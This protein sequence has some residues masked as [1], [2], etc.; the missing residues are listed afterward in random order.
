MEIAPSLKKLE[1]QLS[2][3]KVSPFYFVEGPETFLFRESLR[4]LQAKLLSP[5]TLD[6]NYDVFTIGEVA[7]ARVCEVA[8]TLPVFSSKRMI[9]CK[10]AHRMRE[11]DSKQLEAMIENPIDTCVLVFASTNPDKRKKMI[12]YLTSH[13]ELI[14]AQTPKESEWPL[15]IAWMGRKMKLK[16]SHSG[17]SL[18]RQ[19]A[20]Y[21]LIGLENEMKKLK[22]FLGNRNVV[23]EE[24]ILKIVP[25][26]KPENIFALSKAIG[27]R[28]LSKALL[29][30]SHLLE[31]NQNEI[32]VLSL[33]V[34]HIRILARIKE[35]LKK[36]HR[37]QTLCDKTG[38][39]RF[40]IED[41]M[42]EANLWSEQKIMT[43]LEA[44]KAT[45]KALKS[46]PV[47]PHIWLEN[48]IIK[49]CSI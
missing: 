8:E 28:N 5:E 41:Y 47:S 18:L 22:N 17:V 11:S 27:R 26:I 23:S 12:K 30:L 45:D 14:S 13:C 48:F 20:S 3:N 7:L 33:V 49:T 40:F 21:D 2:M 34:R 43:T 42:Q 39:P 46:S 36:G 29:C 1:K 24:D 6:F 38:V 35:G 15:W 19:Y 32:G 31:D 16:L 10:E 4:M 25:R 9:V 44:L 37:V